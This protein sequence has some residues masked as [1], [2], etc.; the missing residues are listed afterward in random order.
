MSITDNQKIKYGKVQMPEMENVQVVVLMGGIGSRLADMTKS[1]PKPMLPV[2]GE[3]FFLYQ[4]RLLLLAGFKK[5]LFLV[6]YHAEQ[7]QD[8]FA[9]GGRYGVQ[10]DYCYDGPERLGTAGAVVQAYDKLDDSFLLLYGDTLL[11]IDYYEIVYRF[12]LGKLK[13]RTS[14][15]A[16]YHNEDRLDTSNVNF[17]DGAIVKYNKKIPT[18]NMH[19][20]DYGISVFDKEVFAGFRQGDYIDLSDIQ[21]KQASE[22][23]VAACVVRKRFYEIGTPASLAYFEEYAQKRYYQPQRAV[24]VDRDGVINEI[25]LNDDTGQLDSP[26]GIDEFSFM[27]GA[28]GGLRMLKEKGYLLFIV[29]NQPAAAKGKTSLERLY[30]MNG[31]M[32]DKLNAYGIEIDDVQMCPHHPTGSSRSKEKFLIRKC[33]CRKPGIKMID[34]ILKKY[35]IDA[36]TSYMIGDSFTDIQAGK[37]AGL[38]TAFI[39]DFKCDACRRLGQNK[40]DLTGESLAEIAEKL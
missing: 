32:L 39:G 22:K 18:K 4:F 11:D 29:T 12:Y 30:D 40:P 38:K 36:N 1:V 8:Y 25:V 17:K 5:F 21:M 19:Y 27:D 24:F 9:D 3:P 10:I 7:I 33:G 28:V 35:C 15:M 31:H 20:I 16:V 37:R 23:L 14:L 34:N 13:G 26:L 2:C 6:G